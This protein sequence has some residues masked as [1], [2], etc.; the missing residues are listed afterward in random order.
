MA[1]TYFD[2]ETEGFDPVNHKILTIQY[3]PD[4]SEEDLFVDKISLKV[5]HLWDFKNEEEMIK[6]FH[7]I[8]F[9]KNIWNFIL[10]GSNLIFDLTFI[11]E[12]F[13]KYNLPLKFEFCNK[14]GKDKY[15]CLSELLYDK[16]MVDLKYILVI[17]NNFQFVGSGLDKMTNKKQEGKVIP[18][19]Y[20]KK[21]YKKIDEYIQDEFFS[22]MEALKKIREHLRKLNLKDGNSK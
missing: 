11:F 12:K 9:S 19:Y 17:M 4:I 15:S 13:E 7:K 16:P 8:F 10:L 22:F 20:K 3:A 21:E 2:I 18:E 14:N 1:L 6:E 5:L